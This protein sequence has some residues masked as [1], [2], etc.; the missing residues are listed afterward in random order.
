MQ[1]TEIWLEDSRSAFFYR[2]SVPDCWYF[3]TLCSYKDYTYIDTPGI[4]D[5]NRLAYQHESYWR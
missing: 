2:M 4:Q 3:F 1:L 5:H